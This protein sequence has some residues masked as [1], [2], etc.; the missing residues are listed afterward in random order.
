[1][2]RCA[3][4]LSI[5]LLLA[6]VL[7]GA[8]SVA[9]ASPGNLPCNLGNMELNNQAYDVKA[10]ITTAHVCPTLYAPAPGTYSLVCAWVSHVNIADE[11]LQCGW[12]LDYGYHTASKFIEYHPALGS[13]TQYYEGNIAWN[14]QTTYEV[15]WGGAGANWRANIAGTDYGQWGGA[16]PVPP[17]NFSACGEVQGN[18]SNQINAGYNY[19]S[20]RL[21]GTGDYHYFNQNNWIQ[22]LADGYS[23]EPFGGT[24]YHYA[25][26]GHGM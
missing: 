11:H 9:S 24:Y 8:G 10:Y 2:K 13:Y 20:Y 22:D 14:T 4:V 15:V 18:V 6:A 12:I 7:L 17:T 3:W 16:L 1:M 21:V 5:P 19:T 26:H 25:V 23:V